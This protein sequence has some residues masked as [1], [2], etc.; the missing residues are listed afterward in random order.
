MILLKKELR[1]LVVV[2][3]A[4]VYALG[5]VLMAGVESQ[6]VLH[7]AA[8]ML[9]GAGHVGWDESGPVAEAFGGGCA[10]GLVDVGQERKAAGFDE[11]VGGGS[12][13][14]GA[15]A[16]DEEGSILNVHTVSFV[17]FRTFQISA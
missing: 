9:V 15:A 12:T 16:G 5:M 8:G 17:E 4:L 2:A 6:W 3:G 10:G 11:R 14:S 7:S 1:L 13:Q